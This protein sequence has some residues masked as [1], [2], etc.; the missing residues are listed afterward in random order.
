MIEEILELSYGTKFTLF[1][2]QYG[3]YEKYFKNKNRKSIDIYGVFYNNNAYI[4]SAFDWSDSPEGHRYW[5]ERED[6]WEESLK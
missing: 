6:W 5:K 4:M 2:K 1:L 3:C